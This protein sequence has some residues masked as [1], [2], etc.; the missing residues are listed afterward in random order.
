MERVI[1]SWLKAHGR[2]RSRGST[3]ALAVVIGGAAIVMNF[4]W[5]ILF[6]ADFPKVTYAGENCYEAGERQERFFLF[7]PLSSRAHGR[8]VERSD[9]ALVFTGVI[10]SVF[11]VPKE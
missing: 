6:Q 2:E 9:P 7:C 5:R 3:L 11:T 4:P 10:E 1:R 8:I